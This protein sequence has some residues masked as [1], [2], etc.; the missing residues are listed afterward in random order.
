MSLAIRGKRERNGMLIVSAVNLQVLG[1]LFVLYS[2]PRV[3][4]EL[5][6]LNAAAVSVVA[7]L[8]TVLVLFTPR[9]LV[10]RFTARERYVNVRRHPETVFVVELLAACELVRDPRQGWHFLSTRTRF[11]H[12]INTAAII[13]ETHLPVA[14]RGYGANQMSDK[15]CREMAAGLREMQAWVVRLNARTPSRLTPSIQDVVQLCQ[16]R[17]GH[18]SCRSHGAARGAFPYV[19]RFAGQGRCRVADPCNAFHLFTA[20]YY[21][22]HTASAPELDLDCRRFSAGDGLPEA[23]RASQTR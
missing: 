19:R 5:S 14:M 22:K 13:A 3:G 17:V 20:T 2:L 23:G 6:L 21:A 11:M 16:W 4:S 1:I 15:C 7:S 18:G 12:R 8:T 10:Y 9:F